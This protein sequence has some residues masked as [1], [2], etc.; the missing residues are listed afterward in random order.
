MLSGILIATLL[1]IIFTWIYRECKRPKDFPKGPRWLP[2]IGNLHLIDA[3]KKKHGY[4]FTVLEKLS[5][6]YGPVYGLKLGQNLTVV[7][8]DYGIMKDALSREEF[9]GR[10]NGFVFTMRTFGEKLGIGFADGPI[11]TSVRNFTMKTLKDVGLGKGNMHGHVTEEASEMVKYLKNHYAE[12]ST[13]EENPIALDLLFK[14]CILNSQWMLIAGKRFEYEEA[15]FV[16]ILNLA[17]SFLQNFDGSG[18]IIS[19][20]PWLRFIAPDASGFTDLNNAIL[21][22]QQYFQEIIADHKRE[23]DVNAAHDNLVD[24]FLAEISKQKEPSQVF[25]EKQLLG[26]LFD[27]FMA[28]MITL[29]DA[30]GNML[31]LLAERPELQKELQEEIDQVIGRNTLPTMDYYNKMPLM[32]AFNLETLRFSSI[33]PIGVARRAMKDTTL[34][35][36]RIPKDTVLVPV[37]DQV[38]VRDE[39]YWNEPQTFQPDRFLSADRAELKINE[40]EKVPFGFGKRRC[41]GDLITSQTM[42]VFMASILQSFTILP[43][44]EK[45]RKMEWVEG[46]TFTPPPFT[47]S[48]RARD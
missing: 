45:E 39:E 47:G 13:K 40:R 38:T 17:T 41:P 32:R 24:L 28:G 42:F 31:H 37:L 46:I 3:L 27:L 11:C 14:L 20:L 19:H 12:T 34:L 26:T 35:H 33:V 9:Q 23:F 10:P 5:E 29:S 25:N 18:G 1:V 48:I 43:D 6:E 2:I 4:F 36:Y 15:K 30:M 22:M 44:K 16:Q 8:T 7:I 21:P